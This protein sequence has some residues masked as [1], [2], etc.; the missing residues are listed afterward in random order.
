M[1]TLVVTE[2]GRSHGEFRRGWV[3]WLFTAYQDRYRRAVTA[4]VAP[5]AVRGAV[6]L[7]AGR[8]FVD[9]ATLPA[10]AALRCWDEESFKADA[11][12]LAA[13]GARLVASFWPARESEPGLH[14]G[15]VWLPD[16]LP[17]T[18][19]ILIRLEVLEYLA[20]VERA[21]NEVTPE[22][23][24]LV[25]GASVAERLA[26]ALAEDRGIP[27]EVLAPSTASALVARG[28][29]LL[30]VREERLRLRQLLEQSRHTPPSVT[31]APRVVLAACHPRHLD[32][33][34]PLAGSLAHGGAAPVVLAGKDE[35]GEMEARLAPLAAEGI[36]HAYFMDYLPASD[37]RRIVGEQRSLSRDLRRRLAGPAWPREARH[38]R[39]GL[40]PVITPF[41]VDAVTRSLAAARLYLEAAVRALDALRP[42]AVVVTSDRRYPERALAL[43]AGVRGIPSMLFWG[44]ST[45]ARDRTNTF[46]I[47]DRVLVIG[48]HVR[49]ALL[50]QG[51]AAE[52]LAVA[53]DP[54]PEAARRVGRE[55]LR[56][57]I[58]C[59]F[60][61]VP[62]RPL[63]I[64]VSKYVS[65]LFSPEEKAAFYRTVAEAVRGLGTPNVIV[66]VHPNEDLEL[67][68]Q[69]V[70]AWGWPE[71]VL[72]QAYDI[73]RLF[74]AADAAIMVTS[75]A[76]VEAMALGC[77]VVAVQTR[78]KDFEGEY[79]P[80]YVSEGTVERVDM[81]DPAALAAALGR[82]LGDPAAR[83]DLVERGRKFAAHYLH[84]VDG[85]LAERVLGIAEEIRASLPKGSR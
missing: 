66:K 38:G 45:L 59:H 6:V 81:D 84:P 77:P 32:V 49:T 58:V 26:R 53:G 67:L 14:V 51:I 20:A 85:R 71:A 83:E 12:P 43:A 21:L 79:M 50:E 78:G 25:T 70:G 19:G 1:S 57:E 22:R 55:A 36:P 68:R 52:R 10:G 31:G 48:D 76:G 9:A 30:R 13:L 75:L 18:K 80:P 33:L 40:G 8:E 42:D 73:H 54:R 16:L 37:A 82:I 35:G 24:A 63:L 47:A 56:A 11:A 39:V 27:V 7:L 65:V 17:V 34:A 5:L 44:A 61:L 69:Q 64:M 74:R 15:A 2:A 46:A 23:V 41:A 28:W 29:R 3:R 60:G 4:A 72:T 62:D